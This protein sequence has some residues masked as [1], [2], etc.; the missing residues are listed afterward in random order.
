MTQDPSSFSFEQAYSRLEQIL[1][2]MNSGKASLDESL[3]LYEEA[4]KLISFCGSRL[5]QAEQKIE[6]LIKNRSG[7]LATG[8]DN[9]PQTQEF[10][11]IRQS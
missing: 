7:A 4:D 11:T 8:P 3:G 1:E 2:R 5:T 10:A 6:M 9:K